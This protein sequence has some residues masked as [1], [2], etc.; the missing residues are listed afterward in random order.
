MT[1]ILTLIFFEIYLSKIGSETSSTS[2][3]IYIS[4]NEKI[5]LITKWLCM[6][7]LKAMT[8]VCAI[9]GLVLCYVNYYI[10][11]LKDESFIV[12]IPIM[13]VY[14][15]LMITIIIGTTT[16]MEKIIFFS[17]SQISVFFAGY[18][19][20]GKHHLDIYFSPLVQ[21]AYCTRCS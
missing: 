16:K 1:K 6:H 18:H 19:G 13:F 12:P 20:I 4:L 10:F 7:M 21:P 14:V 17:P 5:E 8:V 9:G 15:L 2:K 3:H 11:D